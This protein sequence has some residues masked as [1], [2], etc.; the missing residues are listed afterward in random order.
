MVYSHE[1]FLWWPELRRMRLDGSDMQ[2]IAASAPTEQAVA[3]TR[4]GLGGLREL[5][6]TGSS[7]S[8]GARSRAAPP[9]QLTDY[10]SFNPAVSPDGSRLAFHTKDEESGQFKIG[11]APIEGGT[12]EIL[13]NAEPTVPAGSF[14]RVGGRRAGTGDQHGAE[15]S[16]ESVAVAAEMAASS[17]PLTQLR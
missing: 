3:L 9:T 16:G 10:E 13:L 15:R 7:R 5:C 2:V 4:R 17:E 12:P 1:H 8:G 6:G 14:H 11:V